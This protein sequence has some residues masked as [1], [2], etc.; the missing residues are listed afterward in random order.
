MCPVK[1]KQSKSNNYDVQVDGNVLEIPQR[2][3][4]PC[5]HP[6]RQ[7]GGHLDRDSGAGGHHPG[8]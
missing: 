3:G 8:V 7:G 5:G 2:S 4:V 1:H 6:P